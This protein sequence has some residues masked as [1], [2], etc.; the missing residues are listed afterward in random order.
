MKPVRAFHI[1]TA[2]IFC[3]AALGAQ[4]R[5]FD[6]I[7]K[8]GKIIIATEGA[9]PPFNYFQGSTLTGFEIELGEA[10]AKKMGVKVEWKALAFDALLA[11]L[12]YDRWDAV[13]AGVTITDER[14]KA[15]TFTDPHW[16]SGGVVVAK[17]PKI[18]N[19][20]DLAGKVVAVQTGTTY[21][22]NV[23]KINGVKEVRNFPQDTDARSALIN[24]RVDVWVSDKFVAKIAA[25]ANPA[26]GL[27]VGEL[28]W[29]ERNAPVVAKGNK[30]LA[31]AI[32]KALA[33][34]MADGTYATISNKY[35]KENI[36]CH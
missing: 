25:A 8:D 7:K 23:K 24:N 29:V 20:K 9:Y 36:G 4:A 26:A 1:L 34:V 30:S 5:T 13:I 18:R 33:E 32:N 14:A 28:L 27:K 19:A 16:C 6:E 21:L 22:D 15:V 10:L 11:G 12:R 31:L 3:I 35:L 17:D 2:T